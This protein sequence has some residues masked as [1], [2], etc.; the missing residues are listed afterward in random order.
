[1]DPNIWGPKAWFFL[2]SVTLAYPENP[3]EKQQ[4]DM[5]N[6]FMSIRDIL[7]C[8]VCKIHYG[9]NIG[10]GKVLRFAVR[11]KSSLVNWL[12]QIHN[13][14]NALN[15]KK[16]LTKNDVLSYYRLAY[17]DKPKSDFFS[18]NRTTILLGIFLLVCI[19]IMKLF[20]IQYV[21]V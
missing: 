20:S 8:D 3:N 11:H 7:P 1:M 16:I 17:N 10:D 19:I 18:K 6:F 12:I 14:V 4:M 15:N 13:N 2:H 9:E 21:Q 5:Y